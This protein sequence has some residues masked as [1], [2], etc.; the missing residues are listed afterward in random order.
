MPPFVLTILKISLLLLLYF[1]IY[2][3]VRAVVLDLYGP[4]QQRRAAS[5][6]PRG[7]R[8]ARRGRGA[9]TK[10]VVVDERGARLG[11]HRLSGTL[12]IGRAPSCQIRPEDTYISQMHARISERNGSWVVEDLG[13]T[14]G[15]YLNQRKVTVPTELSPGDRI[16]VGKTTLE[17]RR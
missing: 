12:Q 5:Q 17:V 16:R 9:P 1:F 8:P 13:S 3:A 7:G 15:T 2:R 14:N 10:V 11:S 6:P 4:R